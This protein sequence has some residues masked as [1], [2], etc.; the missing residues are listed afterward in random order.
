[1]PFNLSFPSHCRGV[2]LPC[3]SNPALIRTLLSP[4][5]APYTQHHVWRPLWPIVE[6]VFSRLLPRP[7]AC[8]LSAFSHMSRQLAGSLWLLLRSQSNIL[9]QDT[10]LPLGSTAFAQAVSSVWTS[11]PPPSLSLAISTLSPLYLHLPWG[12]LGNLPLLSAVCILIP[13]WQS[14]SPVR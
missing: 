7:P 2:Q 1:M 9:F 11:H 12:A 3:K 13:Y 6:W 14:L 10:E 4:P 8:L 5:S